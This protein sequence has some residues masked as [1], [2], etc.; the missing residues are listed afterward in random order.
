MTKTIKVTMIALLGSGVL[1]AGSNQLKM[2]GVESGKIDYTISGS[3]NVMGVTTKTAGKKRVIFDKFGA[4]SLTEENRIQK[5]VIGEQSNVDKSHNLDYLDGAMIYSVDLEQ[6]RITRMKNPALMMM[7][8]MGGENSAMEMGE[9]MLKKMGGKKTGT[10]KVL[11]YTCDVWEAMGTKQCIYKGIP[12]K[13]ES[14]VMG[15]KN[16]EVATKAEFEIS[17]SDDDFKLP[18]F[19]VYDMHGKKVDK[20]N[21]AKL[22][23]KEKKEAEQGAEALAAA[24]GAMAAAAQSVGVKPGEVPSASQEK[25]ME[26]AMMTSMLPMMKQNVLSEEKRMQSA[27]E[28]FSEADT[29]KE[30]KTCSRNMDEGDDEE[31]D[32]LKEWNDKT[33]KETLTQIDQALA[34]MACIKKAE[35]ME[36][37]KGCMK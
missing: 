18:D 12:L 37:M 14:N 27:K 21:L 7:N 16:S 17:L 15:I 1:Y 11:G 31:D 2:Y 36:Q 28:C 29:I 20:E 13:V 23:E 30:A 32:D 10:D 24:M 8:A 5:T 6:K 4:R 26:N 19:P 34:G 9:M 35:T 25:A 3:G 33:K 22:D